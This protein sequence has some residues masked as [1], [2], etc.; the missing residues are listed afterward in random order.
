[1]ELHP[2]LMRT[3]IV[4]YCRNHDIHLEAYSPLARG[5]LFGSD[6]DL[7]ELA[8]KYNRSEADILLRWSLQQGFIALPKTVHEER[9]KSNLQVFDFEMSQDDID[10]L[11]KPDMYKVTIPEWDPVKYEG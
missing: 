1:M 4:E 6:K 7:T 10:K 2:W 8:K 11:S 5:M 9:L 3:E